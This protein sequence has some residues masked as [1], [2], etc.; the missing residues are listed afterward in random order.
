MYHLGILGLKQGISPWE[1]RS[2]FSYI[3]SLTSKGITYS[4][5]NYKG[6][7]KVLYQKQIGLYLKSHPELD[8]LQCE[9][10]PDSL[11][12]PSMGINLGT[13]L[14]LNVQ[15]TVDLDL[16]NSPL[17]LKRVESFD[18]IITPTSLFKSKLVE[19]GIDPLKISTMPL[20]SV[21]GEI[22]K[23]LDKTNCRDILGLP[24]DTHIVLCLGSFSP[25]LIESLLVLSKGLPR[26][27]FI[28]LNKN[29]LSLK[30]PQKNRNCLTRSF[31]QYNHLVYWYNACDCVISPPNIEEGFSISLEC[32]S[33][34][35]PLIS[36]NGNGG[37]EVIQHR[38]TGWVVTKDTL[39][40]EEEL[41]RALIWVNNS[42][43]LD[44]LEV[45]KDTLDKFNIDSISEKINSLY[46]KII[47]NQED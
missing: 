43:D 3:N 35:T 24:H 37:E 17:L 26:F 7:S 39:R 45:L 12:I 10:L 33:C 13:K 30:N 4:H 9:Y 27:L 47:N 1:K 11:L 25:K 19:F 16:L 34:N 23:P 32:L 6:G 42:L 28:F 8:I 5:L 44:N 20:F 31:T 22:F 38:K 40:V 18:K 29:R 36:I 15:K 2:H 46:L 14:C 41:K 21:N